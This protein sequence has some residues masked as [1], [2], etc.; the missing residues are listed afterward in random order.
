[1]RSN[2]NLMKINEKYQRKEI[3]MKMNPGIILDSTSD[4][5]FALSVYS[6]DKTP[7]GIIIHPVGSLDSN[8]YLVLK[9][10]VDS[11]SLFVSVSLK[12]KNR[13]LT[14]L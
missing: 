10:K 6:I 4:E 11:L 3:L 8:S 13:I 9:E 14:T 1:M 2:D 5:G 7:G 12:S